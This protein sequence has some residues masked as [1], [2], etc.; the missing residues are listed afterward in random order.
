[1]IPDF[2]PDF[3]KE[4]LQK[5][6]Q[7]WVQL[8]PREQ[9]LLAIGAGVLVLSLSYLIVWEPFA[10]KQERLQES[11]ASQQ[12]LVVWMS[13]SVQELRQLRNSSPGA[14][15][16]GGQS[17]LGIID[18]SAKA[19]QLGQS[20]TRVEPEGS[21]KVRVWFERAEFDVLTRWMSTLASRYGVTAESVTIDKDAN[22]GR[23]SARLVFQGGV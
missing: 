12:K 18:S 6:L 23:V 5:G 19:A 13:D 9:T 1:M 10:S 14:G 20:M 4:Q 7:Y 15:G 3:M 16:S 2:L 22:A 8:R 21:N 11:V 17:L